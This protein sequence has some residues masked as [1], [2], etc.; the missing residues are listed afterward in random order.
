MVRKI[1]SEEKEQM[2]AMTKTILD[3]LRDPQRVTQVGPRPHAVPGPNHTI[4]LNNNTH[5]I[6]LNTNGILKVG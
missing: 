3:E 2:T 6:M 1:L 4:I 5:T